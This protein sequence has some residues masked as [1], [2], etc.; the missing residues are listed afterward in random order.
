MKHFDKF[1]AYKQKAIELLQAEIERRSPTNHTSTISSS[2]SISSQSL[3]STT[4]GVDVAPSLSEQ[5]NI[6]GTKRKSLLLLCFDKPRSLATPM[7]EFTS[8]MSSTLTL[9]DDDGDDILHF[10]SQNG[11]LF[12]TIAV[13]ARDVLAI[14]A[15]NTSVERLFSKSKN[16]IT[17]KRTRM[18][19][20]KI[21]RLLFLKK[22]LD[23]FKNMFDKDPNEGE[24]EQY[25]MKRKEYQEINNLFDKNSKKSKTNENDE[26]TD[27]G[28]KNDVII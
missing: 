14:P 2:S 16:M 28:E 1:P 19:V 27:Q 13:I 26:I 6:S 18:G 5:G 17:D 10:W 23:I 8:W 12:P 22:N 21:D 7:D 11:H 24:H 4:D 3:T 20:E 15:S 25:R 9:A